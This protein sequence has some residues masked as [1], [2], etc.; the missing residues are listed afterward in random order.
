MMNITMTQPAFKWF[1]E[2][3]NLEKNDAVRFYV[4][5]GGSPQLIAGFSIGIEVSAPSTPVTQMEK[6]GITFFI[7]Q[8]DAWYFK[9]H[10]LHIKF[11]R[12][13]NEIEFEYIKD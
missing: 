3:M 7:E 5:Y 1:L 6:D 2:E 11:S 13:I 12:K 9:D 10:S 4:R 8:K